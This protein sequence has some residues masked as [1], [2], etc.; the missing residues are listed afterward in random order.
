MKKDL[1]QNI[2]K[3]K[4]I[5]IMGLGLLGRGIQVSALLAESGAKLTV[6]D[7]KTAEQLKSSVNKLKKYKIKYVLGK[8]D[9]NDFENVDLI[10]KSAGVPL[11]S[12]FIKHARKNGIPI[13]M[14]AS[15]F[16]KIVKQIYPEVKII[17]IT[18][19]RGKSMTTAL[20]YHLLNDNS[21]TLGVNVFIGG[22]MR[23]TAT[24]PILKK[25]NDKDIVVLELDSWQCQGFGDNKISPDIAVFTN[26]MPDH[27]NYYKNS[28]KKYRAD[29]ENIFKFQNINGVLFTNQDILKTLTRK[30]KGKIILINTKKIKN[31]D[32]HIFGDHNIINATYA[33]GVAREFGLAPEKI[34][35]SLK[36]FA[37]LEGRLQY[38]FEFHKTNIV[39]DNN[40]TTPEATIAG[41]LAVHNKYKRK[42]IL[43]CGG[44]DKGLNLTNLA[45]YIKEYCKKVV[46][47]PGSGTE[48]LKNVLKK[49]FTEKKTLKEAVEETMVG[50][51]KNDVI[52]FSPGFASFGLF[53]NEYDRND[54]FLKLLKNLSR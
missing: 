14:D 28:M 27:M 53:K 9:L 5:T 4:K 35:K 20:T 22:N 18:G 42:I 34:I 30:P 45:K 39:N 16:T 2:F 41:L 1:Y 44:A 6:T 48:K 3:N 40:A 37:G 21:K 23:N 47:L 17:G 32:M 11:D 10:I 25:I 36:T 31:V 51:N 38:I 43:L 33:Y 29:K 13:E 26:F 50:A 8:H 49:D 12:P 54:Q 46:L 52:L 24:L 15:F 19:T 7:L